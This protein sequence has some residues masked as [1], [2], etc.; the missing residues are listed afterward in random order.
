MAPTNTSAHANEPV[1]WTI[2]PIAIGVVIPAVLP[3]VLNNRGVLLRRVT[4]KPPRPVEMVFCYRK[5]NDNPVLR[6]FRREVLE[7]LRRK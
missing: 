1:A 3:K 2:Y 7:T 5:D 4:M 6:I